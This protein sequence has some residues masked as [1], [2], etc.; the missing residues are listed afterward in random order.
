MKQWTKG[1]DALRRKLRELSKLRLGIPGAKKAGMAPGSLVH[2]GE[3]VVIQGHRFCWET[4]DLTPPWQRIEQR[5][6]DLVA[7]CAEEAQAHCTLATSLI[8]VAARCSALADRAAAPRGE[9]KVSGTFA[10]DS[11]RQIAILLEWEGRNG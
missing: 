7:N 1:N 3:R 2:V 11:P 4:I 6:L 9:L 10:L 8:G 5:L